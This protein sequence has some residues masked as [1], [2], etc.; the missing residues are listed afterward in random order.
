MAVVAVAEVAVVA[1]V[2]AVAEVAVVGA[3]AAVL[4]CQLLLGLEPSPRRP[5]LRR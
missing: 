1:E 2:A 5:R 4:H 3:A